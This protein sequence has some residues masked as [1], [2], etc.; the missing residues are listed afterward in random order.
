MGHMWKIY[1]GIVYI[2]LS[3]RSVSSWPKRA[4]EQLEAM[5]AGQAFTV[6]EDVGQ[7]CAIQPLPEQHLSI[8]AIQELQ[9]PGGGVFSREHSGP[10]STS[11]TLVDNELGHA[12]SECWVTRRVLYPM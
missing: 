6:T 5:S 3:V 10:K 9:H 11:S 12:V 2:L 4:A 7:S 8:F 1:E